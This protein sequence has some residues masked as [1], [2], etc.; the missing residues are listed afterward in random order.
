LSLVKLLGESI[1]D[2]I[3][4]LLISK[5]SIDASGKRQGTIFARA[6]T[7]F[8]GLNYQIWTF[9]RSHNGNRRTLSMG[10]KSENLK[11]VDGGLELVG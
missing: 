3:R 10:D 2:D 4:I 7:Y 1:S 8:S 5:G 11:I 9:S 6:E